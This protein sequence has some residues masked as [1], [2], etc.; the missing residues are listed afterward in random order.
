MNPTE[1]ANVQVVLPDA[2][3][4]VLDGVRLGHTSVEACCDPPLD[5]ADGCWFLDFR[6]G[7][8]LVVVEWSDRTCFGVSLVTD[9]AGYGERPDCAF[10]DG[11]ATAAEVLRLLEASP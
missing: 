3:Q 4:S 2:L 7:A 1:T 8:K 6:S 10:D 9:G 5:R 11:I